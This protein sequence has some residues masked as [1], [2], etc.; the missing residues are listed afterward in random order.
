MQTHSGRRRQPEL[1]E[2]ILNAAI[3]LGR[4][5]GY[6][7][8]TVQMVAEVAQVGRQSIYRRWASK[9]EMMADALLMHATEVVDIR[10][11]QL[12]GVAEGGI[13]TMIW[14]IAKHLGNDGVLTKDFLIACQKQP[15]LKKIYVEKVASPWVAN[16][17][18]LVKEMSPGISSSLLDTIAV[19][20]Q[21]ALMY[22]LLIG[23]E[24]DQAFCKRL[25]LAV[26]QLVSIT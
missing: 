2:R 26:H 25:S 7:Q 24:L 3:T 15:A 11:T 21:S 17:V 10:F 6:E 20:I 5:L 8:V 14:E 13:Y 12:G 22:Q 9:E 23:Y 18:Q 1:D 4:D 19:I 16:I